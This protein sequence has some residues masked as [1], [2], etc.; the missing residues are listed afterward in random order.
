M[1]CVKTF[2]GGGK[3]RTLICH[4]EKIAIPRSLRKHVAQWYHDNLCHP[5]QV[6]MEATIRQHFHW[7]TLREDVR[8]Y[9]STCDLCQRTKKN[10]KKYGLLPEKAAETEPWEV[11]CVDLIRPYTIKQPNGNKL[12]L[13]CVTMIDPATGCFEWL[14]SPVKMPTQ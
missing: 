14:R 13:W 3:T 8:R 10:K 5:G 11:L 1:Y 12:Q 2:R 9:C 4:S 7:P 6:R